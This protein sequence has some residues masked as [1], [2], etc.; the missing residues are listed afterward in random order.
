MTKKSDKKKLRWKKKTESEGKSVLKRKTREYSRERESLR[1]AA[2]QKD[3]ASLGTG[4]CAS[5][6]HGTSAHH[7][8]NSE[9][10]QNMFHNTSNVIR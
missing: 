2:V 9:L 3:A 5:V 8:K 4:M 10:I 7:I 1:R 6:I